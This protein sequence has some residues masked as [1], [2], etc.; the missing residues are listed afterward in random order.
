MSSAIKTHNTILRNELKVFGGY[1]VKTTGDGIMASF[2]TPTAALSWSLMVQRIMLETPWPVEISNTSHR[3]PDS[4]NNIV[5]QRLSVRIGAHW[6]TPLRELDPVTKRIDYFGDMINRAS[7]IA[8]LA[9]GGEILVSGTF[10]SELQQSHTSAGGERPNSIK[11]KGM[12][13]VEAEVQDLHLSE[14]SDLKRIIFESCG[15]CSLKGLKKQELL[16]LVQDTIASV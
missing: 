16:Y 11:M 3:L 5:R 12:S 9:R 1:E 13:T 7:R 2:Q 4:D 8:A 14:T 6:G 15:T 10:F